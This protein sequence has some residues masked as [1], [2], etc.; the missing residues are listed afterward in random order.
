MKL[1]GYLSALIKKFDGGPVGVEI[2]LQY[3]EDLGTVEEVIEPYL[4][5]IGF[6]KGRL[7]ATARPMSI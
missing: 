7:E 4:L 1:I 2:S 6:I 3:L 5:Q